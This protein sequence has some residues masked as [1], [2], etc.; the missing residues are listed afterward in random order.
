LVSRQ[1][2]ELVKN[3]EYKIEKKRDELIRKKPIDSPHC[4]A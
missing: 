2:S 3:I 4:L 1:I